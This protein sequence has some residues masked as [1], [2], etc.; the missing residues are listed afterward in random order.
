MVANPEKEA[1]LTRK[2]TMGRRRR[3]RREPAFV[4]WIAFAALGVVI[5]L[6]WSWRVLLLVLA[7]WCVYELCLV[8]TACRVMTRQGA[9]CREQVRG[10]LFACEPEHQ[11]VKT[12]A[13]LRLVGM[14]RSR[15]T[16]APDPNRTTGVVV[17]SP[18]VRG[19]LGTSDRT[20]LLLTA[21]GTV[22]TVIGMVYGLIAA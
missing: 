1:P 22:V 11:K 8:P 18:Q 5:W 3:R 16:R 12:E 4:W 19:R 15:R 2:G 21:V 17:W 10:R 9:G 7:L 6:T 20:I 13:L 14:R